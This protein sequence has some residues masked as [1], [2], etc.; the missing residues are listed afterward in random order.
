MNS[1]DDHVPLDV[2]LKT[3]DKNGWMGQNKVVGSNRR[4]TMEV[5]GGNSPTTKFPGVKFNEE[6]I[7]S[8]YLHNMESR[9]QEVDRKCVDDKLIDD[10]LIED[11]WKIS[12]E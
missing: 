2:R 3:S 9:K 1:N 8:E 6:V 10:T 4:V 7:E 5:I 12:I 11:T